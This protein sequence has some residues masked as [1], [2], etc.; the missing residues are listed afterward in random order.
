MVNK[1]VHDQLF[2]IIGKCKAISYDTK[3]S[4]RMRTAARGILLLRICIRRGKNVLFGAKWKTREC[5]KHIFYI[6]AK[7]SILFFKSYIYRRIIK[8]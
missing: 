1:L 2:C 3:A 7:Y 4:G 8:V 6:M 5:A